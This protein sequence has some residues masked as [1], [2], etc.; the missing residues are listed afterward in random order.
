[1]RFIDRLRTRF[2]RPGQDTQAAAPAAVDAPPA[3]HVPAP[4]P[5]LLEALQ[6]RELEAVVSDGTLIIDNSLSI[7]VDILDVLMP[8]PDT[9]RVV[10]RITAHHPEAFPDGLSEFL[11]CQGAT[12]AEAL[13]SALGTWADSDLVALLDAARLDPPLCTRLELKG[14][15]AMRRISL[16]PVVHLATKPAPET[17]EGEA[18]DPLCPC[19]LLTNSF[20]ALR[21][22]IEREGTIGIRLFAALS[23]DEPSADCRINGADFE[24]GASALATWAGSWPPRGIEYRKQYVIVRSVPRDAATPPGAEASSP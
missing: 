5:L 23:D 3:P 8:R 16:G 10:G 20:E 7:E 22:E 1:M 14:D 24:P 13:A 11:H 18:H 6:A 17:S 4:L 19:C 9:I 12:A 15:A 2:A 21:P